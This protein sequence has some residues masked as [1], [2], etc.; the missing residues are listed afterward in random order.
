MDD[1]RKPQK[2]P[3]P[4]PQPARQAAGAAH[5]AAPAQPKAAPA[6]TQPPFPTVSK[7][8][9]VSERGFLFD[10]RTGLTYTLNP[11]GIFILQELQKGSS[12]GKLH[13]DLADRFDV[14]SERAREDLRDFVQ[15][16]KD[17]G[18]AT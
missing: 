7:D 10:P 8:L 18:L 4:Q 13:S 11:T 14:M 17:F 9:A 16:L 12:E 1:K 5:E 15:Q 2:S 3:G 6:P